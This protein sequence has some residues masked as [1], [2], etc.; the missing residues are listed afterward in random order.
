MVMMV[1]RAPSY[2]SGQQDTPFPL[3]MKHQSQQSYHQD[4]DDRAADDGVGDAGV[5]A[6]TV[7]Q[8]HKVLIGS[9]CEGETGHEEQ[10]EDGSYRWM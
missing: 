7:V 2:T 8:R 5:V 6:Q 9:F 1:M 3:V 4:E 10:L